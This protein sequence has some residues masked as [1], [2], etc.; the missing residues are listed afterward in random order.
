MNMPALGYATTYW[1]GEQL[2]DPSYP[3]PLERLPMDMFRCEFMG[4]Q[5]GVPA[6]FLYYVWG[7]CTGI[8]YEQSFAMALLHDVP[9][10][11]HLV[12]ELTVPTAMWGIMD[13]FGRADA[14][15]LP[16][17]DNAAVVT[18]APED[19]YASLYRRPRG[20]LMVAVANMGSDDRTATVSLGISKLGLADRYLLAWDARTGMPVPITR[21]QFEVDLASF[22]WKLIR[23]RAG[24]GTRL[25][26]R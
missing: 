3:A 19:V 12:P 8:S 20:D 26:L 1:D 6:E 11:T 15:F 22:G 21:G 17:W 7:H 18:V 4:R 14:A 9:V 25:I 13:D 2:S 16:Y 5:W 24:A 10:R 23:V